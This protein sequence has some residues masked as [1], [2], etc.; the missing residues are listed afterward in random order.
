MKLIPYIVLV[1]LSVQITIAQQ[2][3]F[4]GVEGWAN[5]TQG[6]QGGEIIRVTNLNSS[7]P[8]SFREAVLASFPRIVVFEVGGVIDLNAQNISIKNPF[9]TIAGQTAPYPGITII[10]GQTNIATHDVILQHIRIRPGAAG[11]NTGWEPDGLSTVSGSF[12]IID[13]CSFSWAV[14][15]NCSA[16]G[17]RFEGDTPDDWRNNTSHDVTISNCI[18][19]EALAYATHT[20]GL[21][22][23][24]SLIHDNATNIAI[25]KNLYAHNNSRNPL[26]KGGARG[27]IVNNMIYDPGKEAIHYAL[28]AAEWEGYEWQSGEMSI[29]GNYMQL[30]I[31]SLNT[32]LM[33][34]HAGPCKI[35]MNNN[36]ALNVNGGN[37][38]FYTGDA[39]NIVTEIPVWNDNI[40]LL[41]VDEVE[42]NV[43]HNA[44]AT[45]WMRDSVD[46]RIINDLINREGKIIN[47]E[48][49]VGGY[50]Q[51]QQTMQPFNA[52]EWNL[53]FM[54][55]KYPQLN[56]TVETPEPYHVAQPVNFNLDTS[57]FMH[58]IDHID[59]LIN[60]EV[61]QSKNENLTDWNYTFTSAE[62]QN[63]V[64]IITCSSSEKLSTE[65]LNLIIKNATPLNEPDQNENSPVVQYDK[66]NQTLSLYFN[67]PVNQNYLIKILDLNGRLVKHY[68]SAFE[69]NTSFSCNLNDLPTGTYVLSLH[70]AEYDF[71]K[72]F[73]KV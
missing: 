23:M 11:K 13:H 41:S 21:H 39:A 5:A 68:E 12:V 17:P 28:N 63:V 1:W 66:N 14:D 61:V 8:G 38:T 24:G 7:G 56:L 71:R 55:R 72:I 29:I 64:L 53:D 58:A 10:N 49:E 48:T 45:P 69:N 3:S 16:S 47:Y 44:G 20:K 70:S 50:P 51:Y 6:G 26:F 25:L 32:P 43:I 67:Q 31:S 9:L 4:Y 73:F 19:A 54:I 18:I 36:R 22:S 37:A 60:D 40:A 52:D 57:G 15:E 35:Y 33:K 65:T 46:I 30:G 42:A 59:L 27:V 62:T 34:V 2:T